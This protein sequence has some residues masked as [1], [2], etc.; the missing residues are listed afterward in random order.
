MVYGTVPIQAHT[1]SDKNSSIFRLIRSDN[2]PA[3]GEKISSYNAGIVSAI[4]TSASPPGALANSSH[5]NGMTGTKEII[6]MAGI[7]AASTRIMP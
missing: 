5:S 3:N 6:A 4:G 7:M 2:Q 1:S